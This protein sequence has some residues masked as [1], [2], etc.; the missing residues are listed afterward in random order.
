MKVILLANARSGSRSLYNFIGHHLRKIN[1][2]YISLHEPFN[3]SPKLTELQ[4]SIKNIES[5]K[6]KNNILI[7]SLMQDQY[8]YESFRTWEEYIKWVFEYFDKIILL[9]RKDKIKQCESVFYHTKINNRISINYTWHTPKVYNLTNEDTDGVQ[10]LIKPFEN[11]GKK[12]LEYS[13]IYNVPIF[14]YE[15]IFLDKNKN[16]IKELLNYLNISEIEPKAYNEWIDNEYK[17]VR[18]DKKTNNLI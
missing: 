1:K 17:V 10:S 6:G 13:N 11:S 3:Y 7:K 12:M 8:P 4:E 18:I 16:L 14:Y 9:D 15:D 5:I 2:K